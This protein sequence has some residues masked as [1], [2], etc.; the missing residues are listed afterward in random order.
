MTSTKKVK[1]RKL[2]IL[3]EKSYNKTVIDLNFSRHGDLFTLKSDI[4]IGLV[5][6]VN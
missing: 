3:V 6:S 4:H 1:S 2:S 5:A